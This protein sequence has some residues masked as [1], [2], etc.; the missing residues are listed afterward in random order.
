MKLSFRPQICD[1][2]KQ[3]KEYVIPIDRGT[4]EIVIAIAQ[5]IRRKGLNVIHPRREMEGNN[6]ERDAYYS[7][8]LTSNQVGNLS[9]PHRH[10]LIA[11]VRGN[12]GRWCLTSKG[13]SFLRGQRVAKFAIVSKVTGHQIGYFKP[14]IY[15]TSIHELLKSGA[16]WEGIDFDIQDGRIVFERAETQV[17]LL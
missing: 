4:A 3:S 5:A 9:R 12:P 7:G 11:K 14:E 1:S 8:F 17:A 13:A 6:S 10:G 2:C 15:Q 16:R